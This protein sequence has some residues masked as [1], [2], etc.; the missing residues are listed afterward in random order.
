MSINHN[1]DIHILVLGQV[2]LTYIFRSPWIKSMVNNFL[3]DDHAMIEQIE[4]SPREGSGSA[5]RQVSH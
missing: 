1:Y 2:K 5:R 3:C 4:H